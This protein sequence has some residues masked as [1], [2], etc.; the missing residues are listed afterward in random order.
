MMKVDVLALGMLTCIRA[1]LIADHKG[2]L[3]TRHGAAGRWV[4]YD[5]LCGVDR[6]ASF[7]LKAARK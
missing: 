4:V 6:S 5:I 1:R 3:G 2:R 7:G